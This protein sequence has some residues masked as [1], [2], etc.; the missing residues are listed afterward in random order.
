MQ[1]TLQTTG[2]IVIPQGVYLWVKFVSKTNNS[3]FALEARII[4]SDF[5]LFI[6]FFLFY[7]I[8]IIII[9][10][11]FCHV[12]KYSKEGAAVVMIC[13]W[14][15]CTVL[16]Y[17]PAFSLHRHGRVLVSHANGLGLIPGLG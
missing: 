9:I 13:I 8:I 4:F 7:F 15:T 1:Y 2:V 5:Y 17:K 14:Y 3:C 16:R 12:L 6:Y 10:I 11:L